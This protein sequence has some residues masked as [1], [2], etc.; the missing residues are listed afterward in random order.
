MGKSLSEL[1]AQFGEI[2]AHS[3]QE[4]EA[5]L[6]RERALQKELASQQAKLEDALEKCRVSCNRAAEAKVR[7]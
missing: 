4:K 1:Q 5:S 7:E 3:E 2:L 6:A